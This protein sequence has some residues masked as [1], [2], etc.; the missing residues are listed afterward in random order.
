MGSDP[1]RKELDPEAF[2]IIRRK[3]FQLLGR[4]GL[5]RDD[6]PDLEQDLTVHVLEQLAKFDPARGKLGAFVSRVVE[7]KAADIL[8]ARRAA[9]RD[10]RLNVRSLHETVETPEGEETSLEDLLHEDAVRSQHGLSGLS[11]QD[12]A[13]LRVDL[14]RAL[15][16][17]SPE[18]QDL[19]RRLLTATVSEIAAAL[20]IPR[21]SLYGPLGGIRAVFEEEGL[22]D[23]L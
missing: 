10:Y 3:A 23:Y 1:S 6:E 20:G 16:R 21:T 14:Q 7:H 9:R 4:G 19:C 22:R 2:R 15:A 18:Q 13:E 11:P 8:D 17:L 5:R 12:Q